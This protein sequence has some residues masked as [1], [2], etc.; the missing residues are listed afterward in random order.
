MGNSSFPDSRKLYS[1]PWIVTS[2]PSYF[3]VCSIVIVVIVRFSGR[4]PNHQFIR[5][6]SRLPCT[7][8]VQQTPCI[9]RP[10][11]NVILASPGTA[12]AIFQA[13][14]AA[15]LSLESRR[16]HLDEHSI[17]SSFNTGN[18]HGHPSARSAA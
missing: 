12:H 3:P 1:Q 7:A 2:W 10:L 9:A 13:L 17:R 5:F 14:A 15:F 16:T 4:S 8:N 6:A 11:V 18:A